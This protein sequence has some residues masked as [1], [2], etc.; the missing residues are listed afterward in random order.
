MQRWGSM[1]SISCSI[2]QEELELNALSL[3]SKLSI[4]ILV[5]KFV[6]INS[7]DFEVLDF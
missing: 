2:S 3:D 4:S 1:F 6:V 5:F 7:L